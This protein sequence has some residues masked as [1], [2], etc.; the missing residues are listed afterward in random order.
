[1]GDTFSKDFTTYKEKEPAN[2]MAGLE[3]EL[4]MMGIK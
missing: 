4:E 3:K 1:M 2:P